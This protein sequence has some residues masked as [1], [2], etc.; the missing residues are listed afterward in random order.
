MQ[1]LKPGQS[2]SFPSGN[3][4]P[5]QNSPIQPAKPYI[6]PTSAPV[7]PNNNMPAVGNNQHDNNPPQP[8]AVQQP[9]PSYAPFTPQQGQPTQNF[10]SESSSQVIQNQT[11]RDPLPT[12]S[13]PQK[14]IASSN[15]FGAPQSNP[16]PQ[17]PVNDSGLMDDPFGDDYLDDDFLDDPLPPP[18]PDTSRFGAPRSNATNGAQ[19]LSKMPED[20]RRDV[21]TRLFKLV[22]GKDPQEK[23]F[24]YYRFS[25]LTE[26]GLIRNLLNLN[27]HKT[28]LENA[29]QFAALKSSNSEL[30][31]K[32]Q[33]LESQLASTKQE[34]IALQELISEKNRHIASLRGDNNHFQG[35]KTVPQMTQP[36][37]QQQQAPPSYAASQYMQQPIPPTEYQAS[38]YQSRKIGFSSFFDGVKQLVQSLISGR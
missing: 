34:I 30:D 33:L 14:R 31:L 8:A 18:T 17:Y 22:L 4:T 10:Q 25:A 6:P 20:Q 35:V 24:N 38:G 5:I 27:E 37:V 16:A 15:Q 9:T 26:D 28:M 36:Q 21:I 23:D 3:G 13:S 12:S 7:Q 29:K 11:T 19:S 1:D 2:I 32:A